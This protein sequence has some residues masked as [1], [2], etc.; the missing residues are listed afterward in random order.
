MKLLSA[1]LFVCVFV[2]FALQNTSIISIE[3]VILTVAFGV[4]GFEVGAIVD[5][6]IN[7][8][9]S[10]AAA[11]AALEYV[12]ITHKSPVFFGEKL[13]KDAKKMTYAEWAKTRKGIINS[14]MYD[15]VFDCDFLRPGLTFVCRE[16]ETQAVKEIYF[17]EIKSEAV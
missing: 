11:H 5:A 17:Y 6:W 16:V 13:N 12:L 4:A 7:Q 14:G 15:E 10:D 3:F 2:F 9:V 1:C 8:D